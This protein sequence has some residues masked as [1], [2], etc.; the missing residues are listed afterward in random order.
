M[1]GFKR[2]MSLIF[3]QDFPYLVVLFRVIVVREFAIGYNFGH[4]YMLYLF[5]ESGVSIFVD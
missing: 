1:L 4:F 3:C 2:R 5:L